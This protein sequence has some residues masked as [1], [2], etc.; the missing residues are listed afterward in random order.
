ME[1]SPPP[2]FNRGPAPVVRVTFFALLSVFLM[3]LDARFRYTEPLRQVLMTATY[4]LQR[5]V[6]A[7]FEAAGRI[8][9]YFHSLS[10]LQKE[11][12]E[13]RT[14]KLKAA[15]DL[16]TLEALRA[17]NTQLRGLLDARD[18]ARSDAVFA[19]IVYGSRD[20]FARRVVIDKGFTQGIELGRPVIDTAGVVG[21]VTRVTP[22]ASEVTL[23]THKDHSIPV[24]VVRNGL[25]AIAYGASEGSAMELRHLPINIDVQN[26]DE[27]ITSGI[28]GVYPQGLP[29]GKVVRVDRDATFSFARILVTPLAGTDRQRQVLVLRPMEAA[30]PYPAA[31]EPAAKKPAKGRKARRSEG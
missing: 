22:L 4:P 17:E 19:E 8:G 5:A 24:Q 12:A 16:M 13:L 23:I 30:P 14:E 2:F 26:D 11:N 7:P 25:R 20:P 9:D 28:D 29:V 3:V 18:R 27:L 1:H 31:E 6:L 21:Q 15:Q 10:A